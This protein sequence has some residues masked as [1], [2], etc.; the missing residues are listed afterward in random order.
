[1]SGVRDDATS[2][3]CCGAGPLE[4]YAARLDDLFGSLARRRG[5]RE[6][7]AG[8][9]VPRDRDKTLTA[10]AGADLVT[11]AQS[12]VQRLQFF[13]SH[14]RWDPDRVNASRLRF[15]DLQKFGFAEAVMPRLDRAGCPGG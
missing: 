5:F 10:L 15:D 3:L 6:Y 13:L 4:G 11:G 14:S 2:A 9:L 7:L 8:L 1:V 12:A